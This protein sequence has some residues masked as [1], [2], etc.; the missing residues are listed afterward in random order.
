MELSL[1]PGAIAGLDTH[2]F[3]QGMLPPG[4]S[5]DRRGHGSRESVAR[6]PQPL[7]GEAVCDRG[8]V[9][10]DE[11]TTGADHQ[12]FW[13]P[14]DSQLRR[15]GLEVQGDPG[16]RTTPSTLIHCSV[17]AALVCSATQ[18]SLARAGAS[19]ENWSS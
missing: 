11:G 6:D 19:P 15:P 8:R 16:A 10:A 12:T 2:E 14:D 1:K 3:K 5:S 9:P 7:E 13:Q 18:P 17:Q 4:N